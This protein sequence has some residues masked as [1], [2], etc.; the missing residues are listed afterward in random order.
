METLDVLKENSL[1]SALIFGKPE[2]RSQIRTLGRVMSCAKFWISGRY[3]VPLL[4]A[5]G[6]RFSPRK[7]LF[8]HPV[9][10]TPVNKKMLILNGEI[11]LD[12]L[13]TS[14]FS[15]SLNFS[16]SQLHLGSS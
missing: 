12:H 11:L 16:S 8:Y 13:L 2:T 5:G 7:F 4:R 10:R 15:I 9:E 6:Y 3:L 14:C 1:L